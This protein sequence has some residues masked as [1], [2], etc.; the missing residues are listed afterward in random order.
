MELHT[1]NI[2]VSAPI[3]LV[4]QKWRLS[5]GC[6]SLF[7]GFTPGAYALDQEGKKGNR[8][9]KHLRENGLKVNQKALRS[10]PSGLARTDVL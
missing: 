5:P 3:W 4:A 8:N 10:G 1:W 7:P 9:E 2:V 6:P